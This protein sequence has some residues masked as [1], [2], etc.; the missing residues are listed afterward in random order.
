[1]IL[2]ESTTSVMMASDYGRVFAHAGFADL[3][4]EFKQLTMNAWSS[5]E[6]I[7]AAHRS[8]QLAHLLGHARSSRLPTSNFPGPKMCCES[9]AVPADNGG[10]LHDEDPDFQS[11]QTDTAMSTRGDLQASASAASQS[12]AGLRFDD[13]GRE[14]H[15]SPTGTCE[16]C[17]NWSA[18]GLRNEA[19][20]EAMSAG[21]NPERQRDD[22]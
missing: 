10:G 13:A 5:Q 15:Q 16:E 18:A 14:S 21:K 12:V 17:S 6:R 1:M 11:R 8:N 9:P 3:D 4:A 20:K 7:F 2:E 19:G 22:E